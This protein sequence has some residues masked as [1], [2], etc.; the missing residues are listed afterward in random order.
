MKTFSLCIHILSAIIIVVDS[1]ILLVPALLMAAL[2][3]MFHGNGIGL[4]MILS[5]FA[6]LA[7]GVYIFKTGMQDA[8]LIQTDVLLYR[9]NEIRLYL[10]AAVIF[11]LSLFAL[12]LFNS[13]S[14]AEVSKYGYSMFLAIDGTMLVLNLVGLALVVTRVH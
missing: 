10:L 13:F 8:N 3:A 11:A 2:S 7:A 9:S 5:G 1:L 14:V 4:F 12:F 6:M